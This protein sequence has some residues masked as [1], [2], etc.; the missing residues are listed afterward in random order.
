[1]HHND[2]WKLEN[3]LVGT[4]YVRKSG[5]GVSQGNFIALSGNGKTL[6]VC[7]SMDNSSVGAIWVF[8]H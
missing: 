2:K 1:M 3:K 7:G 6:A 4:G 5:A 8:V